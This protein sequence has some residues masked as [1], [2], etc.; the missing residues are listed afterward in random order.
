[1]KKSAGH[2]C[3]VRALCPGLVLLLSAVVLRQRLSSCYSPLVLLLSSFCPS[4]P[5]HWIRSLSFSCPSLERQLQKATPARSRCLLL[6]A[7]ATV[8]GSAGGPCPDV[9]LISSCYNLFGPVLLMIFCC[10]LVV[11][12]QVFIGRGCQHFSGCA[13]PIILL[14]FSCPL[15]LFSSCSPFLGC[16]PHVVLLSF[17]RCPSLGVFILFSFPGSPGCRPPPRQQFLP[18]KLFGVYAG[19]I[20]SHS[21]AHQIH[22]YCKNNIGTLQ[23]T[24]FGAFRMTPW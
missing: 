19:I 24:W 5:E 1:M 21:H 14:C 7:L 22:T 9:L 8:S 4:A 3:C 17:W 13:P 16:S 18:T 15:F 10:F 11:L 12:L 23:P 20:V 6:V 2:T